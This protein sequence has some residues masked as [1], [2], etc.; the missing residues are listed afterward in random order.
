MNTKVKATFSGFALP[1]FVATSYLR[2]DSTTHHTGQSID[3]VKVGGF[4][5]LAEYLGIGIALNEQLPDSVRMY[6]RDPE[7]PPTWWHYH[8]STVPPGMRAI[9]YDF[10]PVGG[11]KYEI[12]PMHRRTL[13][14]WL[15]EYYK[16]K[17]VLPQSVRSVTIYVPSESYTGHSAQS[18][19]SMLDSLVGTLFPLPIENTPFL[20]AVAVVAALAAFSSID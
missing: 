9:E 20:A 8:L 10:R 17:P 6:I 14:A 2:T 18:A 15:R 1:D 11:S 5:S 12:V 4:S 19:Q 16:V 3:L 13:S 7:L